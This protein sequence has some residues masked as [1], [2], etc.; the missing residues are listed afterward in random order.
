MS[1]V[2]SI[3]SP[4]AEQCGLSVCTLGVMERSIIMGDLT[5]DCQAPYKAINPRGAIWFHGLLLGSPMED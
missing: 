5:S 1:N 3:S 2:N 4:Q